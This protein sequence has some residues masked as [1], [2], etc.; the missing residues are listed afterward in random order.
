[1]NYTQCKSA[2]LNKEF[3]V[4]I[5]GQCP[6]GQ[7]HKMINLK[8]PLKGNIDPREISP[9]QCVKC[10]YSCW[11]FPEVMYVYM[12]EQLFHLENKREFITAKSAVIDLTTLFILCT[13][14]YKINI[15]TNGKIS[16][17]YIHPC[18]VDNCYYSI[19]AVAASISNTKHQNELLQFL[20]RGA[21]S[22][23]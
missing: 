23:T 18:V 14:A 5:C 2:S 19:H 10:C 17:Q 1:M 9:A 8:R 22:F 3:L 16:S 11:V 6:P 7:T 15:V 20:D 21:D 4:T 13:P 12:N